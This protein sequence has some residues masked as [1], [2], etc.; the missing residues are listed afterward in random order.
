MFCTF[1]WSPSLH[2]RMTVEVNPFYWTAGR[3][4][5]PFRF[6]LKYENFWLSDGA[7]VRCCDDEAA[8]RRAAGLDCMVL[9]FPDIH[10][11]TDPSPGA[12]GP[13]D[14]QDPVHCCCTRQVIVIMC[15]RTALDSLYYNLTLLTEQFFHTSV[16]NI[17]ISPKISPLY[18]S[19]ITA[20]LRET[21]LSLF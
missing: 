1:L 6:P 10:E 3:H 11:Y 12:E 17:Q 13:R 19:N 21:I 14:Q 8:W 2:A 5:S 18:R 16:F 4:S 9:S 7:A 20:V 15:T